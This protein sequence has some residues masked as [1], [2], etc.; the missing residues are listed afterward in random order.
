MCVSGLDPTHCGRVQA[1]AVI[2]VLIAAYNEASQLGRL[3]PLVPERV[4]G[5]EVMVAVASDGSTDDTVRVARDAGCG[6]VEATTNRGKGATLRM[7]IAAIEHLDYEVLALMDG[8]GQHDPADLEALVVPILEDRADLVVGSRYTNACGREQA[9]WNRYAVRCATTTVLDRL[10][11]RRFSD[12]YCGF[13]AMSPATVAL[14]DLEGDRY[15]S[16]LEMLFAAAQH[17]LRVAE[18]PIAKV[19]GPGTSKMGARRGLLFGRLEVI[20]QYAGAIIR[21]TVRLRKARHVSAP[22]VPL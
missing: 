13:R 7:G 17:G 6:T 18:I 21:R 22:K 12:P 5:H 11:G 10:L 16:E 14:I 4:R 20:S 8:D 19:Y 3:L 15:Q 1:R 9:P 2:A